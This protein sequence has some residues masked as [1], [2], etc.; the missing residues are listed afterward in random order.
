VSATG[1]PN[2][3]DTA[4]SAQ[5]TRS[6]LR[7][8]V[9]PLYLRSLRVLLR[10]P[11]AVIPPLFIPVF[12]LVVNTAALGNLSN[13]PVLQGTNY[14]AFF[15]PVSI[16]LTVS[17][18]GSGSGLA[19]VQDIDAGY[20]DKLLLAPISR[21]SVLVSRLMVDG[22][23][24]AAQAL[25]VVAVSLLIGGEIAAGFVGVVLL[26]VMSF[27]FG[28]AYAGIGLTIALR[29][30]STEATQASFIIFFP[31]VFLAPTFV[32]LDFLAEW[33]QTV[34]Q[35]NPVTYVLLGMRSLTTEGIVAAELAKAFAAILGLA[36][37]L[38]FSAFRALRARAYR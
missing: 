14:V 37:L 6:M 30:G 3:T 38:L 1:T 12:F 8:E 25:L 9:L 4:A 18:A 21:T 16:L 24:A 22:T 32:P 23:R 29:T 7:H 2:A 5:V 27:L 28:L 33:L 13:S 31:L 35:L 10:V 17:S 26:V 19:L 34:A 11:S 20:F 15:V 36:A